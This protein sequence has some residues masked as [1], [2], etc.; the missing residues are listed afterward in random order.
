MNNQTFS[1]PVLVEELLSTG[2]VANITF[3]QVIP[4]KDKK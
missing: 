1:N 3:R 2:L 4:K